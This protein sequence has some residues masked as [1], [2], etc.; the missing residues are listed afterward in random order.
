MCKRLYPLSKQIFVILPLILSSYFVVLKLVII[1]Y[2]VLKNR[3][4]IEIFIKMPMV[5]GILSIVVL[6]K[7]MRKIYGRKY[8]CICKDKEK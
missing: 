7:E 1:K 4:Y 8:Y 2:F 5:I 6:V 3:Y